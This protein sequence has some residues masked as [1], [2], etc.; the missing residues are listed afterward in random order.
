MKNLI[1]IIVNGKDKLRKEEKTGVVYKLNHSCKKSYIGETKRNVSTR[2][3]EHK[4]DV[5]KKK[6]KVISRHILNN[7]SDK[8]DFDHFHILDLEN[9]EQ[10]EKFLEMLFIKNCKNETINLKTDK[11]N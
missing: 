3:K 11:N 9:N 4:Q 8:I 2:I 10:M 7:L 1:I 5:Q 6:D